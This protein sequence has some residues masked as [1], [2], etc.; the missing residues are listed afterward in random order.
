MLLIMAVF[1]MAPDFNRMLNVFWRNSA[2][3]SVSFPPMLHSRKKKIAGAVLKWLFVIS[4]FYSNISGGLSS[5]KQYGDLRPLP[6]LYGIYNTEIV[7]RN[8]DTIPPLTTDSTRWKQLIIQFK[9]NAQVKLMNDSLKFFKFI[10]ND[11]ARSIL[12]Y[13]VADS[14][15]K[16]SLLYQAD[17][18]SLVLSGQIK[19]DSIY[20]RLRKFDVNKFRLVSRGYHWINEYPYNR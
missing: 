5:R 18:T 15:N 11:S 9:E 1:L 13:S 8:H 17:S 19:S 4:L 14:L 20:I 6:P 2:V 12:F 7:V 16:S 10:V 3:Q